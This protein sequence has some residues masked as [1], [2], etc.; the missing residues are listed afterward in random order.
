MET[1]QRKKKEKV[2]EKGSGEKQGDIEKGA[3]KIVEEGGK[4]QDEIQRAE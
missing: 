3:Q 1:R 2:H 4:E